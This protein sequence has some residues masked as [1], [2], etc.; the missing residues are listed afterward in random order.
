MFTP[1]LIAAL[2]HAQFP[3]DADE[4]LRRRIT[5]VVQVVSADAPAV[6]FIQTDG[7]KYSHDFF[8]QLFAQRFTGSGSGVVIMK[9]GFIIT[10]YH[11]VKGA[12][13]ILVT[14]DK[15]YD[16][17]K[18]EAEEVSH[19]EQEDLALLKIYAD[20]DCPTI[21]LGSSS[22]LMPGETVIA[23]GNPLGQTHTVSQGIVSGLHRNVQLPEAKLAFSDLIQT[24][25]A[26]NY[27]NSGGPLININ[28]EMIGMNSAINPN[29]QNIG[30]AIPIDQIKGV[31]QEQLLS[32]ETAPTWLGFDV[33]S[34][35]HLRVA[36]V[37]PGG[38][39]AQAGL[40]PGDC[41]VAI[42][43]QAVAKQDD[44]RVALVGLSP[45]QREVEV[46]VES[47]GATRKMTMN[48]WDKTDGILFEHLGF[49]V[50]QAAVQRTAFLRVSEVRPLGPGE[51]IGLQAG[52]IFNTV[53]PLIKDASFSIPAYFVSTREQLAA[54]VSLLKPGH[55]LEIEVLR[56]SN[57]DRVYS[58]DELLR[59]TLTIQ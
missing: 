12:K 15:R 50:E 5:P 38:P 9:E 42:G 17:Q 21:P 45:Q 44:Y 46:K 26:I 16:D 3:Q 7:Y 19:V 34:G 23:I 24:D 13:K 33:D 53:R 1:L 30:F 48:A 4:K 57:G 8:G 51:K 2:T 35:D 29:A 28:G 37:V 36:H 32:P 56:D 40:K 14:F 27:G 49:K 31:L 43:G 58:H 41:I 10:N 20:H 47:Q 52:D 22:D 59:G 11:V 6:V 55:E 54:I 25:C 39:A 18:Y